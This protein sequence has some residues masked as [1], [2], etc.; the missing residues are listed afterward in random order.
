M[1]YQ[2]GR[3]I[4]LGRVDR[5]HPTHQEHAFSYGGAIDRRHFAMIQIVSGWS[6]DC[7]VL[8]TAEMAAICA[9]LCELRN[10]A[11]LA[12]ATIT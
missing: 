12:Q 6:V 10:Q 2:F 7:R 9:Q 5:T 8:E 3:P 4:G 11:K 1:R